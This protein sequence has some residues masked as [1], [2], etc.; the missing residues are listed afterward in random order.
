MTPI[1]EFSAT[2]LRIAVY[3]P[4]GVEGLSEFCDFEEWIPVLSHLIE[5]YP[6]LKQLDILFEPHIGEI[7]FEKMAEFINRVFPHLPQ[8]SNTVVRVLYGLRLWR[9]NYEVSLF[10]FPVS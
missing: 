8:K 6:N 1:S 3:T 10:N 4:R 9:E 5:S 2:P 7:S